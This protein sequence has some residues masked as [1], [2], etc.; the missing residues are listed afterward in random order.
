MGNENRRRRWPALAGVTAVVLWVVG[1]LVIGG[2]HLGFPGGIPE[3]GASDVLDFYVRQ[4]D[5]VLAGSWA[6]MLGAL[7]FAWFTAQLTSA[8]EATRLS[9][10]NTGETRLAT[11]AGLVTAVLLVL[12]AAAGAVTALAGQT[13]DATAA[14]ALDG[15][16]GV[17]FI[18]A[19]MTAVVMLVAL[20]LLARRSYVLPRAWSATTLALAGWLAVL[21]IG[22]IGLIVGVPLW[23]LATS[24]LLVQRDPRAP[25]APEAGVQGSH[26]GASLQGG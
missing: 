24:A 17:F 22:W 14:Q 13:L 20:G 16:G 6:F 9:A 26:S 11:G 25:T 18:G 1:V 3:E 7:A 19:E 2:G 23:T 10:P 21:P 8:L 5:R 4:G 12:S 15:V